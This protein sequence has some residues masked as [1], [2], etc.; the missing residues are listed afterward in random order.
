MTPDL[1][2]FFLSYHLFSLLAYLLWRSVVAV[3]ERGSGLALSQNGSLNR[4][5]SVHTL[6]CFGQRS[7]AM[8]GA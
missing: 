4:D 2:E 8:Q 7:E 6:A 1:A 3:V 5:I